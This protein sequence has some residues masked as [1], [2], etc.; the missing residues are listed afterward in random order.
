LKKNNSK[1]C[2]LFSK[3][4]IIYIN[5]VNQNVQ[6]KT[7]VIIKWATIANFYQQYPDAKNALEYW[8]DTTEE[9]DWSN[10]NDVKKTFNSADYVG[11]DRIVF[12]IKGNKYRLVALTFFRTRTMYIRFIGTHSAYDKIDVKNI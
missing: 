7:M 5:F 4:R 3:F 10:V 1:K 12:N 2:N 8:Y 11:N 6:R 9:A